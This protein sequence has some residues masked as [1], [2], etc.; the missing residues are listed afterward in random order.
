MGAINKQIMKDKIIHISETDISGGSS[1][2]GFRVHKYFNSLKNIDSKMYVL[3]KYSKD[4]TIKI[5][6]HKPN[7]KFFNKINFFLLNKKNRY[8]FYNFGKYVIKE[9]SQVQE[10]IDQKPKAIILYNNSNIIHPKIMNYLI[11][12][13][14][15]FFFYLTDMELI[16]GGCHYYFECENF[17]KE[18]NNCPATGFLLNKVANKNL[19]T[20]K[21]NLINEKI[22]FLVP[23]K[24]IRKDLISSSIF[25]KKKHS[26]F[27]FYLSLN[28]KNYFE[29]EKKDKKKIIFSFR[30]SLNPRKG[31]KYLI[32]AIDQLSKEKKLLELIHFNILGDKS[33]IR[34][35]DKKKISYNFYSSINNEKKLINFYRNS[36]FFINQSIQDAGPTMVS[37]SLACGIPVISFDVGMSKD[38]IKND[39]NGYLIKAKSSI[40]LAKILRK[41]LFINKK[42]ITEMRKNSRNT[43]KRYLDLK[44]NSQNLLNIIRD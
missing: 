40:L 18:C 27:D 19:L 30:S 39:F 25:N 23:N 44:K 6:K 42:K 17:K 41:C 13:K 16:T 7:I 2:Y 35:L 37:E 34:L 15:K 14:I 26:I 36:D 11:S 38:L 1:Y 31:Q 4:N 28:L 24:K 29:S 3:K 21:K 10:I 33:I 8:S 12:K 9:V 43:A 5:F 20:K 32:E 22:T